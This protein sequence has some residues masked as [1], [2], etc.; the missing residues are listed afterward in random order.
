MIGSPENN[1]NTM[2]TQQFGSQQYGNALRQYHGQR[3][4]DNDMDDKNSLLNPSFWQHNINKNNM[5]YGYQQN[6][7]PQANYRVGL[8]GQS[9]QPNLPPPTQSQPVQY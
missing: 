2:Q 3:Q 7:T 1:F 6:W 5:Q 8:A 4:M 9:L